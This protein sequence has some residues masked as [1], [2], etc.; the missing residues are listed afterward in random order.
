MTLRG[1]LIVVSA[2]WCVGV[3]AAQELTSP[4]KS[5]TP[6]PVVGAKAC[7]EG[8]HTIRIVKTE[9]CPCTQGLTPQ[10]GSLYLWA[11]VC[12]G[13]TSRCPAMFEQAWADWPECQ[14][15]PQGSPRAVVESGGR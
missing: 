8:P 14:G 10:G 2:L 11:E 13:E 5:T 9:P 12:P 4:A 1:V 6:A 3:V 15:K 7:G